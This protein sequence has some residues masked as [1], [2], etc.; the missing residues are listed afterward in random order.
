MDNVA[1]LRANRRGQHAPG[2]TPRSDC[3]CCAGHHV[4]VTVPPIGRRGRPGT[5][6]WKLVPPSDASSIIKTLQ[7]VTPRLAS[8]GLR[9]DAASITLKLG[10]RAVSTEH[11][12]GS[13][14]EGHP[15]NQGRRRTR[16]CRV[17]LLALALQHTGARGMPVAYLASPKP[18]R[19]RQ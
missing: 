8:N 1:V 10:E 9:R 15:E 13:G 14:F 12:P 19:P 5:T 7:L 4:V 16:L 3:C 11:R 6:R 17:L 18:Y 2:R